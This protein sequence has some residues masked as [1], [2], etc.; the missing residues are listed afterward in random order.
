MAKL[1]WWEKYR[2]KT[3]DK[4]IFQN[5]A[6]EEIVTKWVEEGIFPHILLMGHRGTGKTSLAYLLKHMLDI[7]DSDF[8]KIDGSKQTSVDVMRTKVSPFLETYPE[9]DQ[10]FKVV[11]IDE[12]EYLSLNAQ[13]LL[14]GMTEE[15][16]GNARF[17]MTCNKPHKI[18]PELKSRFHE[19]YFTDM[20]NDA[21]LM[22]AAEIL[23]AEKIKVKDI[24]I[25]EE[26]I[27]T[28]SPDFR[29]I[30]NVLENNCRDGVLQP[31]EDDLVGSVE[32]KMSLLSLME[33]GDWEPI[34]EHINTV[35]QD[36]EW[37]E[38][39]KFLYDYLHEYSCFA[40]DTA[41]WMRGI[42]VI[43]DHLYRHTLVADPEINFL[44]CIIRLV[45]TME[46]K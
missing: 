2:P 14:R 18:I 42:V 34:R 33:S 25:L 23:K 35:I 4:F 19:M 8:M 29:K 22:R 1:P 43:N 40:E 27:T 39:Y 41:K 28:L 21:L 15:C 44:A 20:D 11:F 26:Y 12:S 13:Y 31:F 38:W 24:S 3:V 37:E 10:G 36:G 16:L 17:I 45:E 32:D 6:Q 46:Q 9:G 30:I 7:P 5:D